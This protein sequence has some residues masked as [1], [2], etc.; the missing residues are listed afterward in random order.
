[1]SGPVRMLHAAL[2]ICAD[3][4]GVVIGDLPPVLVCGLAPGHEGPH[5]DVRWPVAWDEQGVEA[6]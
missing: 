2:T 3:G 4:Y 5:R 1:M 6:R